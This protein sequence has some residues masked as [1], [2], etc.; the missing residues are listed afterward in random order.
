MD[1]D[2]ATPYAL[3]FVEITR[4]STV[5]ETFIQQIHTKIRLAG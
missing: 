5:V 4:G 3:L 2:V 1:S